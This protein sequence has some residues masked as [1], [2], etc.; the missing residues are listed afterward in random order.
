MLHPTGEL[1]FVELVGFPHVEGAH[2]FGRKRAR[3]SA[4]GP[5]AWV[6]PE[7]YRQWVVAC[8]AKLEDTINAELGVVGS[9]E[10]RPHAPRQK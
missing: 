6:D 10:E 3:A 7:G 4:E 5:Q 9:D 2:G 1:S 8:R